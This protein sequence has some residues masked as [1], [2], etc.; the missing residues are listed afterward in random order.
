MEKGTGK[1]PNILLRTFFLIVFVMA[2]LTG[3]LVKA[4]VIIEAGDIFDEVV[5]V[6]NDMPGIEGGSIRTQQT[7][8]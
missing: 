4:Q 2:L 7:N 6:S 5:D 8:S 1:T 3:S